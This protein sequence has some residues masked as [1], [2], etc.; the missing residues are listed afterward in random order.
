[1]ISLRFLI[2]P[3]SRQR[4]RKAIG[5]R[6]D[7]GVNGRREI[8]GMDIGP[9][10]AER[11]RTAFFAQACPSAATRGVK[12]I[13]AGAHGGIKAA[14][15]KSAQCQPAAL[16]YVPHAP[17]PGRCRKSGRRIVSAFVAAAFAWD[18]ADRHDRRHVVPDPAP[19][20][21]ALG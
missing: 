10:V 9:S 13:T 16:P 4:D 15:R 5:D 2:S 11:L 14:I 1:L 19:R 21:A 18:N 3:K 20:E 17:M 6:R 7:V 8:P 12:P